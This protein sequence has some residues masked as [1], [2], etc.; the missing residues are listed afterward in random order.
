MR[1]VEYPTR[2]SKRRCLYEC[3]ACFDSSFVGIAVPSQHS[4]TQSTAG[5][6]LEARTLMRYP[7][8]KCLLK[9]K[10]GQFHGIE[11]SNSMMGSK[12]IFIAIVVETKSWLLFLVKV[13]GK[14][15]ETVVS[16]L[17]RQMKKL[18]HCFRRA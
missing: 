2:P 11:M 14:G 7:S 18:P 9:L 4:E 3:E 10:A 6:I 5:L 13:E 16:W 12:N 15:T 1:R 17:S 8:V